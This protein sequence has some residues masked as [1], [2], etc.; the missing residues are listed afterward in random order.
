M[1]ELEFEFSPLLG[2]LIDSFHGCTNRS[3]GSEVDSRSE[4]WIFVDIKGTLGSSE[5]RSWRGTVCKFAI[6][7]C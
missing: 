2:A 1:P 6:R 5:E 4:R 7:V 3:G